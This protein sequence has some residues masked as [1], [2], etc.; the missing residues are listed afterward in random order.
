MTTKKQTIKTYLDSVTDFTNYC[1]AVGEALN[2]I[3]HHRLNTWCKDH[4]ID[5]MAT[6]EKGENLIV[7]FLQGRLG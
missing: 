3:G 1:E 5:P 7:L 4:N 2:M 6:N